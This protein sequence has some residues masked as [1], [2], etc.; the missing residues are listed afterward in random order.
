MS[1]GA[2][3]M[4]RRSV[5]RDPTLHGYRRVVPLTDCSVAAHACAE[6]ARRTALA[7]LLT[8]MRR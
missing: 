6:Q 3:S 4:Y 1:G 7:P 5:A 8:K 2:M